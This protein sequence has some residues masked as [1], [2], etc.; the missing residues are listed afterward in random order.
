MFTLFNIFT[1]GKISLYMALLSINEN[2]NFWDYYKYLNTDQSEAEIIELITKE[3]KI[4][5]KILQACFEKAER[6]A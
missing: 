5:K 2:K 3:K 4:D 6:N 1:L